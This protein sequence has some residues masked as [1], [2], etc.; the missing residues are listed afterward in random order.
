MEIEK[1][2]VEIKPVVILDSGVGGLSIYKEIKTVLPNMPVVYCADTQGFPYGPR[3][4]LEVIE[5]TSD[6]LGTLAKKY[7]PALAV[8]ACNTASTISLPRIRSELGFPVVGV[9][10]AIK[11]ASEIS[12]SRCIGLLATPGTVARAYTE[13]L[14]NNFAGDCHVIRVGSSELVKMA[15]QHLRGETFAQSALDSILAPFFAGDTQPDV[16][17]LGC[18]HFPLLRDTFSCVSP[19]IQWIDSGAAIARRVKSIVRFEEH[20]VVPEDLFV[21]TGASEQ[22]SSLIPVLRMMGFARVMPCSLKPPVS[23]A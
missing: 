23:N 13:Q 5:R 15:E 4:E 3:P 9:V 2:A 17:V 20:G 18:T 7:D 22:I 21:H 1:T 10:P 6:C 14:I 19:R 12:R 8:I 16:V 11:T